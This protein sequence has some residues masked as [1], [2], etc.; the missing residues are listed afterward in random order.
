MSFEYLKIAT[1]PTEGV[2]LGIKVSASPLGSSGIWSRTPL[3]QLQCC[4]FGTTSTN[5]SEVTDASTT[6]FNRMKYPVKMSVSILRMIMLS[7]LRWCG[8][9]AW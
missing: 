4:S 3:T 2:V 6:G 7:V 9:V 8:I 5:T 1:V